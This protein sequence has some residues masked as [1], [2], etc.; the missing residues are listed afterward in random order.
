[1]NEF[2]VIIPSR[3]SSTRLRKSSSDLN[4]KSLIK[5]LSQSHS[6]QRKEVF[7]ATDSKKIEDH[8]KN[9]SLMSS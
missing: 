6:E 3:L 5:S 7:I 2:I 8:V 9:F 4:G 1:M